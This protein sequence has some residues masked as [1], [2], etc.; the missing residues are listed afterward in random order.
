MRAEHWHFRTLFEQ[1][2]DSSPTD[3][4]LLPQID[5]RQGMELRLL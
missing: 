1:T 3:P 2:F 5:G 4:I